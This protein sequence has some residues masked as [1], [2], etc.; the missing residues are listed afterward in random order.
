[1]ADWTSS[2]TSINADIRS[3]LVPVRARARDLAQNNDYAKG[4]IRNCRVNIVGPRGFK[5]QMNVRTRD[6]KVDRDT[7]RM[8]QDAWEEW[9]QREH[10]SVDG[11]SSMRAI[12]DL[13]IQHASR[14]G[15]GL[16]RPV[17]RKSAKYGL[18]LQVIEPEVLDETHN[19]RLRNGHIVKM[20]VEVDE[21]RRPVAYYL[22]KYTPELEVYGI[23]S[24]SRDHIVL[25]AKELFHGFD[26]EYTNQT[27]G[28]SWLAQ[29]MYT[30]KMLG[31]FDEA[32]IV[33][34]RLGASKALFLTTNEEDGGKTYG[35]DDEDAEGN[36]ITSIEPGGIEQLP[37]GV[38]PFAWEPAYPNQTYEMFTRATLRRAA[39][40]LGLA[41]MSLTSDL[42]DA[43]Y[44]SMRAG[45]LPERDGWMLI[46]QWFIETYLQPIF[47][48]W[49]DSA[50]M[51]GALPLDIRDFGRINKP[52]FIGRRW[53]WVDPEKDVRAK[54]L[55]RRAGWNSS[56]DVV[57]EKGESLEQIY[58]DIKE[59]E[60]LAAEKGIA[61]NF[62]DKSKA[63]NA[64]D[65]SQ[66]ILDEAKALIKKK[67]GTQVPAEE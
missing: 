6:G 23:I 35:G 43:N 58:S 60:D 61:V 32:T 25:P 1:M 36:V 26:R 39:T 45:L 15:E 33:A 9:S 10:C 56:F 16:L 31:G 54:L 7:N 17:F 21:W 42:S 34:A 63:P 3:G 65:Q 64:G 24:Q 67:N 19:Q 12:Q 5:L 52:V 46:Q 51:S 22:R 62:E 27:R 28:I 53:A 41:Y 4:Y 47:A 48:I 50:I 55:E 20:G 44:S 59:E 2:L 40:G 14:D 13:L 8:I 66:V 37:A 18:Q 57:G 30:L 29:T 38:T 11:M 49:L